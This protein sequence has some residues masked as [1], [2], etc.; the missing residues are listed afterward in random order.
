MENALTLM[1]EKPDEILGNGVT[2]NEPIFNVALMRDLAA[3]ELAKLKAFPMGD[4]TTEKGR[5]AL[6]AAVKPVKTLFADFEKN[7]KV[8][9]KAFSEIPKKCDAVSKLLRDMSGPEI[10]KALAPI[11][12][13]EEQEETVQKWWKK[14]G[15]PVDKYSLENG[16]QALADAQPSPYSSEA[17]IEDYNK[18]KA[19][20]VAEWEK[21]LNRMYAEEK[22]ERA[23]RERQRM[24]AERLRQQ[25]EE[26]RRVAEAQRRE[27]EAL[28][29]ER[30]RVE[31][32]AAELERE[33]QLAAKPASAAT[34]EMQQPGAA[35]PAAE[36][37]KKAMRREAVAALS[38][39]L[40]ACD[41][42]SNF[43]E[44]ICKAI[45]RLQIPHVRFFYD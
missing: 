18:H 36:E 37:S 24:E 26:Q 30:R 33:R 3:V 27:Q 9:K 17:E 23:E 2:G 5:I 35:G 32:A 11:K 39:I 13:L 19:A 25:A 22:A 40:D 44:T 7:I 16:L 21:Q 15:I 28:E 1:A 6:K 45:Y 38:A 43:A 12:E 34:Q 31:A 14:E 20:Y 42:P 10:D 8:T 4:L 29:A 41:L